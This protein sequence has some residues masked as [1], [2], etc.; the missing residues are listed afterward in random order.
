MDQNRLTHK[1]Q[2]ES[3]ISQARPSRH[4]SNLRRRPVIS[5]RR[6]RSSFSQWNKKNVTTLHRS[7]FNLWPNHL[8]QQLKG[9]HAN[10]LQRVGQRLT[11]ECNSNQQSSCKHTGQRSHQSSS[12]Q[13]PEAP[14]RNRRGQVLQPYQAKQANTSMLHHQSGLLTGLEPRR[15]KCW[16]K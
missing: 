10:R 6:R 7:K 4:L 11:Q 5:K 9:T 2:Q 16:T 13:P 14:R 15:S 3:M 8:R 1:V 12:R